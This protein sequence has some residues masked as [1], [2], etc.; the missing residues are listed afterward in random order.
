MR[1]TIIFCSYDKFINVASKLYF[2]VDKQSK[3]TETI[4]LKYFT[5]ILLHIF[6]TIIKI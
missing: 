2:Y 4:N 6:S 3:T 1:H 5:C